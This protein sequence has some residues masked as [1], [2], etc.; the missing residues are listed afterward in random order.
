[1][2]A[3]Y[4]SKIPVLVRL[5]P[6]DF[7]RLLADKRPYVETGLTGQLMSDLT[8]ALEEHIREQVGDALVAVRLNLPLVGMIT[9][10]NVL[11]KK[12]IQVP[13]FPA[14]KIQLDTIRN[15]AVEEF[16]FEPPVHTGYYQ[17]V[18]L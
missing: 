11:A 17:K 15:V 2:T 6:K 13:A 18:A 16:R 3:Q 10:R 14:S 9:V 5:Q 1:M 7:T 8:A 4:Q 12:G